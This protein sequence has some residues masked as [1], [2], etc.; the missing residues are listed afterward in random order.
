MNIAWSSSYNF[1]LVELYDFET[2]FVFF[3]NDIDTRQNTITNKKFKKY[4][5]AKKIAGKFLKKRFMGKMLQFMEFNLNFFRKKF[6]FWA[7]KYQFK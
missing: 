5:K 2:R 3:L 1:F 6:N 7:T 4:F